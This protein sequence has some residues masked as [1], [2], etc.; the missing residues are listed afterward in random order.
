MNNMKLFTVIR[1]IPILIGL[2]SSVLFTEC[3]RTVKD[4]EILGPEYRPA[5]E[6]FA[7]ITPLDASDSDLNLNFTIGTKSVY[8]T[9][10]FSHEVS[11]TITITGQ[12]S[13]AQKI[14]TGLS[15]SLNASNALW[16]GSSSNM[17]FFKQSESA[18]VVLSFLGTTITDGLTFGT[19]IK[20]KS[21]NGTFNG[22]K[23]TVVE[24][25]EAAASS[26]FNMGSSFKDLGDEPVVNGATATIQL[27]GA[28]VY[29]FQGMDK[30]SNSWVAGVTT[31]SLDCNAAFVNTTVPLED[32]YINLYVYGTGKENSSIQIKTYEIDDPASYNGTYDQTTNDGWVY[33]IYATWT[34]WKLVSARYSN[35]KRA[36]DPTLGG[37]G[38]GIKEPSKITGFGLGLNS[39]PTFGYDVEAAADMLVVTEGG[40]FI[41]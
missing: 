29:Y 2:L 27:Q 14:I 28:K 37:I 20:T 24:D 22:V 1:F 8:F 16:D 21:Y 41:P 9:G 5:P 6:G 30:N 26:S 19:L 31:D 38:N 3:K 23:Y 17:I 18:I 39:V 36:A 32:F 4:E 10:D 34:G 7:I 33:D 12:T 25:F 15:N 13:G 35:F 40:P 11:W